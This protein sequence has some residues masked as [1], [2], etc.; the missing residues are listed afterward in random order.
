MQTRR[1]RETYSTTGLFG[2][3]GI[4]YHWKIGGYYKHFSGVIGW[5]CKLTFICLFIYKCCI[6]SIVIFLQFLLTTRLYVYTRDQINTYKY[7]NMC[8]KLYLI[9]N[10]TRAIPWR[11]WVGTNLPGKYILMVPIICNTRLQ[12]ICFCQNYSVY[13]MKTILDL[14]WHLEWDKVKCKYLS[15][16]CIYTSYLMMILTLTTSINIFETFCSR[17]VHALDLRMGQG[18]IYQSREDRIII[19]SVL[20]L[21]KYWTT[22]KRLSVLLISIF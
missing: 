9:L 2:R 20:T 6:I 13:F 18:Q 11:L 3:K 15:C 16:Q 19:S 14:K 4:P 10:L 22:N 7:Y 17:N 1:T 5:C 21:H 12:Y 8:L